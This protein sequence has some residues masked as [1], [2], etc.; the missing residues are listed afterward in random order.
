MRPI[1]MR[2]QHRTHTALDRLDRLGQ[3]FPKLLRRLSP[4]GPQFPA[5]G[6]FGDAG[7]VGRG[8]EGEVE[9]GVAGF[10]AEAVRVDEEEGAFGCVPAWEGW[11]VT[12]VYIY[13]HRSGF[14]G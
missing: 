8:G 10:G 6:G 13:F 11:G 4:R 7:V 14:F 9:V 2:V 5:R 1:Q 3:Q 12:Y